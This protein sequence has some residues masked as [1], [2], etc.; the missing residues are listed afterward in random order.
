MSNFKPPDKLDFQKPNWEEWKKT[1]L[2]YRL[3]SG[4]EEK[5]QRIQIATLKYCMGMQ[6]EEI[7]TT[8]N[9]TEEEGGNFDTM[10]LKFDNYFKPR[11]NEI[12]LRRIF[13]QRV[14]N[15]S[16]DCEQYLRALYVAAEDCNFA[17]KKTRIRDQFISGLLDED[18]A[19]KLELLYLT[20]AENFTI[21]T[22][23]EYCRTY[24]DVK[25]S[26]KENKSSY[27]I[28]GIKEKNPSNDMKC[29]SC[30]WYHEGRKCR[31]IGKRCNYCNRVNHFSSVCEKRQRDSEK[32]QNVSVLQEECISEEEDEEEGFLGECNINS[33]KDWRVNVTIDNKDSIVFK[34]DT[35]ADVS[36]MNSATYDQLA[37]KP[38]LL[39]TN[40]RLT[41]PAG[42][43]NLRGMFRTTLTYKQQSATDTIYVLAKDNTTMNLLSRKM[44]ESLEIVQFIGV[45]INDGN[46]FGFGKWETTPV[47]L[48]LK[49]NAVPHAVCTAPT[50]L[51]RRPWQKIG[52]DLCEHK[53][54]RYLVLVDYYSRWIEMPELTTATSDTIILELNSIFARFGLPNEI[55]SDGGTP[56]TSSKFA[57]FCL[58]KNIVHT[59]SSPRYPQGNGA[60]ERAIQTA[61]RILKQED[62]Y[63]ALLVY[64]ATPIQVT[65]FSPAQ[66]IMGRN[67]RTN[68]PMAES[69]LT[70]QWPDLRKVKENDKAKKKNAD[71]YNRSHGARKLKKLDK[72]VLVRERTSEGEWSEPVLVE[73]Q[74]SNRN[75]LIRNRRFLQSC[76]IVMTALNKQANCHTMPNMNVNTEMRQDTNEREFNDGMIRTRSGRIVKPIERLRYN[77]E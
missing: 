54:K 42:V 33:N 21:E 39:P 56:F 58:K 31:A 28:D 3:I 51:P 34:V 11:R 18:L 71:N 70:P 9:L 38:K 29:N 48:K 40:R 14:Q 4:L 72:G 23:M 43:I 44:S 36:I 73:K 50:E 1:F 22:V 65:G 6:C 8:M 74:I 2:T 5:E 63:N 49:E 27:E 13:H 20:S 19:E 35:G 76:P 26:R 24:T 77:L 66:L 46:V 7:I 16:E 53:G 47:K 15:E 52:L 60:A 57:E 17:D 67:L 61:K 55:R 75:Y 45:A 69:T 12:R 10:I 25:K 59:T 64:R 62:P 41:C 32:R 37:N 30:G 68:I